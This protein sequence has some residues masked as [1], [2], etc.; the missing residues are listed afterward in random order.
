MDL[1]CEQSTLR[2]S[3][4]IPG[5]KSHTI[6]AVAIASLADGDSV[7][8]EPL[9]S[10][11]TRSAVHAYS[12][13]GA[14]IDASGAVWRVHGTSGTPRTPRDVINV[15][16]SGTSLNV[17]VGSAALVRAG[18]SVF[19]GDHQIRRRP[20]GPLLVS[21][22]DLGARVR[23]TLDN[24]CPPLVVEGT[25]RGGVTAI[26]A[27]NSQYLTSLLINA[28]LAERDTIIRVPLLRE[29]PYIEM[30]LE[31]LR[32]QGVCV[33]HDDSFKEFAIPGG[34]HYVPFDRAIPGDFSS[35]TFFLA[36]GALGSNDVVC[37]G[38]D[39]ADTQG[40]RFVV[41]YLR[42]MG[43]VVH[44]EPGRIGI[45][46]AALT[47]CEIDLNATPDALPMMAVLGCFAQGT[48]RLV[49]VPQARI[50]ETD[51]ISV[52]KAE[53][54]RMGGQV[55]ELSDGLVVQHSKLRGADVD[56]HDDHRVIMALAI[57]ATAASGSTR[58]HGC[59]AVNVTF[60]TF[61]DCLVRLG[62]KTRFTE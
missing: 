15:G 3:V 25:L 44:A 41:D 18:I 23:S 2:G 11:D 30:T 43:A 16:N 24:G 17:S 33:T 1:I 58:I 51:R 13:L 61:F 27:A 45:R 49:N 10:A 12:L 35:A 40:D 39:M 21:L 29:R 48:T 37:Q 53:L 47:G 19:T 20:E 6:R 54:E 14:G 28:P 38:L 31:W 60:P 36:A 50:K 62:A 52:M 55:E 5:S 4:R 22:N 8:R 57:A 56:G 26:E 34:Q 42:R 59:G 46:A 7:I 9:D 32:R